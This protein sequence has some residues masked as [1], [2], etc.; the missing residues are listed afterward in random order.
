MVGSRVTNRIRLMVALIYLVILNVLLF[1]E[2]LPFSTASL[3]AVQHAEI[4]VAAR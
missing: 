2:A 1:R 4:G 3:L